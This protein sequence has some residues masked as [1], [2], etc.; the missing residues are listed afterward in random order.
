MGYDFSYKLC[1][2]S[3]QNTITIDVISDNC[4]LV[5]VGFKIKYYNIS[6]T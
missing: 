6:V 5:C 1:F 3:K 4:Y 2:N